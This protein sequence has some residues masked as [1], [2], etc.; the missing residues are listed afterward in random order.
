MVDYQ[1]GLV[2]ALY[3]RSIDSCSIS[4]ADPTAE[5]TDF[6]QGSRGVDLSHSQL[7]DYSVLSEGAG[8]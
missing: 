7:I 4:C 3:L 8:S 6:V 1:V 5:E 2:N